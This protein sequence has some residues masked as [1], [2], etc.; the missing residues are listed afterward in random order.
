VQVFDSSGKADADYGDP[1]AYAY[2]PI[3]EL[4]GA[5]LRLDFSGLTSRA[6]ATSLQ[7]SWAPDPTPTPTRAPPTPVD[8]GRGAT[9]VLRAVGNL[10]P[11]AESGTIL[12]AEGIVSD[13][14]GRSGTLTLLVGRDYDGAWTWAL[15]YGTAALDGEDGVPYGSLEFDATGHLR[16]TSGRPEAVVQVRLD[17]DRPANVSVALELD[18]LTRMPGASSVTLVS[19]PAGV[20][21]ATP[22]RSPTPT[23]TAT[24]AATP[25]RTPTRTATATRT[26]TPTATPT[27]MPTRTPTPT[28]TRTRTP[29]RTPTP[30]ATRTPVRTATPTPTRAAGSVPGTASVSWAPSRLDL[31]LPAAGALE[32]VV[33]LKV[34]ADL[35]DVDVRASATGGRVTVTGLPS[36]VRAGQSYQ[37]RVAVEPTGA[38]RGEVQASVQLHSGR[39]SVGTTLQIRGKPVPT[40][41]PTRTST[42]TATPTHTATP[43][44]RR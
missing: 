38:R 6:A 19:E 36:T 39:R 9:G 24:R 5:S 16:T 2:V 14:R 3:G 41:T 21:V 33:T 30:T 18:G 42:R 17:D 12:W 1:G 7:G 37:L 25:T 4:D 26:P 15:G 44:R 40:A 10:D 8:G 23:A 43:V 29:T 20:P 32:Q 11:A 28:A 22:T 31:Q 35:T 13:G 27:P 34:S